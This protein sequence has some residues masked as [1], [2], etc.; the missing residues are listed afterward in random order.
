MFIVELSLDIELRAPVNPRDHSGDYMVLPPGSSEVVKG[1]RGGYFRAAAY[2]VPAIW[3]G[4]VKYGDSPGAGV[5][6]QTAIGGIKTDHWLSEMRAT[7]ESQDWNPESA[8]KQA[9]PVIK[10]LFGWID[11][12]SP[13]S[14]IDNGLIVP[15]RPFPTPVFSRLKSAAQMGGQT[16]GWIGNADGGDRI[17][18]RTTRLYIRRDA[19][20]DYLNSVSW[21]DG[22]WRRTH[23]NI[24]KKALE[25]GDEGWPGV[26]EAKPPRGLGVLQGQ[27]KKGRSRRF[28]STA[29]ILAWGLDEWIL[30][31]SWVPDGTAPAPMRIMPSPCAPLCSLASF[32]LFDA[33]INGNISQQYTLSMAWLA[34][35]SRAPAAPATKAI[36]E[37][38][39]EIGTGLG[40]IYGQHIGSVYITAPDEM[41][42]DIFDA[43]CQ[44]MP[45]GR[46]WLAS[47]G[48]AWERAE[49]ASSEAAQMGENARI[50]LESALENGPLPGEAWLDLA[51]FG[52]TEQMLRSDAMNRERRLPPAFTAPCAI[53]PTKIEGDR[54]DKSSSAGAFDDDGELDA[55]AHM[56]PQEPEKEEEEVIATQVSDDMQDPES[57]SSKTI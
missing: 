35:R 51:S 16:G 32:Y 21:P 43:A 7:T 30:L 25:Q 44:A 42:P 45:K 33:L 8:L 53:M 46:E 14:R 12:F 4:D 6:R 13:H 22:A 41:F 9:C 54:S 27:D 39:A 1:G 23:S 47:P 50:Q 20:V 49:G 48:G 15:E 18:A 3:L 11:R 24:A 34:S 29:E 37:W 5:L 10:Q 38:L 19:L 40:R 56:E 2:G 36:N 17:H 57:P 28:W 26:V 52:S 55:Q 31:G